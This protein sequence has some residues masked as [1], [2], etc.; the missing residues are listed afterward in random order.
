M[1]QYVGRPET[2]P[3]GLK[4]TMIAAARAWGADG[5]GEVYADIIA[6]WVWQGADGI[7]LPDDM[8]SLVE[9]KPWV[10]ARE[11]EEAAAKADQAATLVAIG[12]ARDGVLALSDSP[13]NEELKVALANL[14]AQ[15]DWIVST[16]GLG[17]EV[18]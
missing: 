16:L 1:E 6:A 3:E 4:Q 8:R 13:T 9:S 10:A 5:I 17:G 14:Q 12:A 15:I 7:V 11:A 2:W 18:I